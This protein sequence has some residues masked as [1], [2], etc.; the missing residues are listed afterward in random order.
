M[1]ESTKPA[2]KKPAP[3]PATAPPGK[4]AEI[5]GAVVGAAL[6]VP[7]LAIQGAKGVTQW[8]KGQWDR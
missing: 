3:K 8:V 6:F 4:T 7:A 1:T 5:A 2:P